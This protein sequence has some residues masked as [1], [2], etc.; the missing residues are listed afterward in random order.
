[1][2]YTAACE[3]C[4]L[5]G[6]PKP[7][8][9]KIIFLLLLCIIP[10]TDLFAS[11]PLAGI[12]GIGSDSSRG[13]SIANLLEMHL[14][15]I[16]RSTNSFNQI[17]TSQMRSQLVRF[18][19]LEDSC[20]LRFAQRAGIQLLLRGTVRDLRTSL[21][22]DIYAMGTGAPYF[23][24]RIYRYY[25][26]IPVSRLSLSTR[27]FSY[28]CEEHAGRFISNLLHR[29]RFP[30]AF[31]SRGD[32]T[33]P[34]Y[35][36][37]LNG[38][39]TLYRYDRSPDAGE[40]LRSYRKAGTVRLK[41]GGIESLEP[42]TPRP[43]NGDFVLLTYENK[44][45]YLNE[46]YRGR[47][48]ELVL[49]PWNVSDTLYIM[50]FTAPA[51]ATMPLVVPVLGH[52]ARGD[53]AGLGLWAVNAAPYIY[54]EADG[55]LNRP[56]KLKKDNRDISRNDAARYNFALYFCFAG[57][58][59]LFVDAFAQDYLHQ[60][61]NYQGVQPLMGSGLSTAYLSLVCGGGG[62]FFRGYRAWGY[63]YFHLNNA[64]MYYTLRE[65][66]RAERYNSA[67]DS[68]EKETVDKT[69]GYRLLG[70]YC[71]LKLIET[72]HAVLLD[73]RIENGE[74]VEEQT[75]ITPAVLFDP[76]GDLAFGIQGTMR[77]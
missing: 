52:Y 7:R 24:A 40:P 41:N 2:G 16:L 70:A 11:K 46:F 60:A 33:V 4:Q 75:V 58:M 44:S 56:Q 39:F 3:I 48:R 14:Y 62:H 20:I 42:G 67:T 27:E 15:N 23:G 13:R 6:A 65:F 10:A 71:A 30:V 68:Y 18:D 34:D 76:E 69:R 55:F 51:S 43:E 49:T 59:S 57:G 29:Y 1:M 73:D 77:F 64:M 72:I 19:C 63:F 28:I 66:S 54:L 47:K 74:L 25:M 50:L 22:I 31:V 38:D 45:R 53:Y 36:D 61:A 37:P 12:T 8:M 35:P 5:S 32:T 21:E 26:R 9:K 17:D